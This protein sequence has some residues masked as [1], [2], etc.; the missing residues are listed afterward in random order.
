M[1][2]LPSSP[3]PCS[4]LRPHCSLHDCFMFNQFINAKGW[5][6][7]LQG[8]ISLFQLWWDFPAHSVHLPH[9][10]TLLCTS[11]AWD[12]LHCGQEETHL[13]MEHP[14][15]GLALLERRSGWEFFTIITSDFPEC[16]NYLLHKNEN[17]RSP[18]KWIATAITTPHVCRDWD[19]PK[20]QVLETLR[21]VWK[22]RNNFRKRAGIGCPI[23]SQLA[24]WY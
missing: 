13:A 2:S 4:P 24:V 23:W 3:L 18:F 14:V 6:A 11:S 19:F 1:V 10:L 12:P 21:T 16:F 7:V 22:E 5:F 8:S 20:N 15:H 17:G 9:N